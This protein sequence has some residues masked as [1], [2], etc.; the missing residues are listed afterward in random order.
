MTLQTSVLTDL[1]SGI[2]GEIAFDG[3]TRVA[4][5]VLKSGAGAA[6]N[7]V[8]RAF[9]YNTD[10]TGVE[11]VRAGGTGRF[12]GI[13]INPKTL[14]LNGTAAG[15]TLADSLV[16]ADGTP[17]ELMIMG[18][19]FVSLTTTGAVLQPTS[20]L[21]YDTTTGAL[22]WVA[23]PQTPGAGKALV[24]NAVTYRHNASPTVAGAFLAVAKLTN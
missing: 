22:D 8:G 23:D 14:V 12:A 4:T 15:G 7:V 11:N 19:V 18:E 10:Q 6:N 17:V 16:V 9:T 13:L 2:V 24:P 21:V 5:A 3:P 20:Y 1:K